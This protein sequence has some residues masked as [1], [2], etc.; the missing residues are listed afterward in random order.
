ML[1]AL[2]ALKPSTPS[3]MLTCCLVSILLLAEDKRHLFQITAFLQTQ[4]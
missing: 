4:H 1:T 3:T 2:A